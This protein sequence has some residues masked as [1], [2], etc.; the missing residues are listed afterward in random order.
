MPR[1]LPPNPTASARSVS[2]VIEDDVARDARGRRGR[3]AA[4]APGR[5]LPARQEEERQR[6]GEAAAPNACLE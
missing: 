2:I 3:R 1:V 6:R 4:A 5:P